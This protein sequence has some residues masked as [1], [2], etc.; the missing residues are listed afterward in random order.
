MQKSTRLGKVVV[1]E[2]AKS[3]C[4]SAGIQESRY[5]SPS[6]FAGRYLYAFSLGH[7]TDRRDDGETH[8]TWGD[9]VHPFPS[10]L[11]YI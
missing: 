7:M 5:E 2:I 8:S 11:K 10:M 9:V 4:F 6:T 3:C 1:V